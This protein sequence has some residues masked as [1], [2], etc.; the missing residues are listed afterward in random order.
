M[1]LSFFMPTCMSFIIAILDNYITVE[2]Q[3]GVEPILQG[4]A[5]LRIYHFATGS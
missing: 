3:N 4:F 2:S 5:V 1:G